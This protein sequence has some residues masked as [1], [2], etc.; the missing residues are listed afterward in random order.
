MKFSN[1]IFVIVASTSAIS[2][3]NAQASMRGGLN[4]HGP[5]CVSRQAKPDGK[6][7][8]NQKCADEVDV[9]GEMKTT[10]QCDCE[11]RKWLCRTIDYGFSCP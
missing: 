5:S 1:L 11:D 8:G 6:C 2:S 9:C 10:L 3:A 7:N 4:R